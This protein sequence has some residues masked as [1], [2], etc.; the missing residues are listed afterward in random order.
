M[1]FGAAILLVGLFYSVK[2]ID[3]GRKLVG[4]QPFEEIMKEKN[5]KE[6][7][8]LQLLNVLLIKDLGIQKNEKRIEQ[9][10]NITFHG[11]YYYNCGA[12]GKE[13][14]ISWFYTPHPKL[15]TSPI[16]F[17]R[18]APAERVRGSC[19]PYTQVYYLTQKAINTK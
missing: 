19:D 2:I 14:I 12:M 17:L 16:E 6:W 18:N 1:D 11:F 9:L 3:V 15:D 7:D 5:Q 4:L 13:D 10:K 8:D